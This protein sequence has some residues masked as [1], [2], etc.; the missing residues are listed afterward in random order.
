MY[1]KTIL[2]A[3]EVCSI[4]SISIPTLYRWQRTGLFPK[5]IKYGPNCSGWKKVTV[6]AWIAT[7]EADSQQFAR[8]EQPS[9]AK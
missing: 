9:E 1:E 6:E 3:A 4:L 7:R 8:H 2:R 5:P